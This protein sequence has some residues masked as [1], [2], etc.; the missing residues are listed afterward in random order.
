MHFY[1]LSLISWYSC[2]I[3]F[4][5]SV[6]ASN[7]S[8][9]VSYSKFKKSFFND[10]SSSKFDSW[11]CSINYNLSKHLSSLFVCYLISE[12]LRIPMSLLMIGS[13]KVKNSFLNLLKSL[14]SW[15][16]NKREKI[17]VF[18]SC[19]FKMNIVAYYKRHAFV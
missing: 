7:F 13:A 3:V 11:L 14:C 2:W 10:S 17:T 1:I 8:S 4:F 9:K 16:M 6:I 5:I 19:A 18:H 15:L 12:S